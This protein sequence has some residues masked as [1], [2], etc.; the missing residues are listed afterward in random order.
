VVWK[1]DVKSVLPKPVDEYLLDEFADSFSSKPACCTIIDHKIQVTSD[2]QPK[3]MRPYR[4][5]EIMKA[6]VECQIK[7][8]LDSG[9]IIRSNSPMAS[10]LV[11]VAKKQGGVR[12]A[13]D[14]R[15]V[16]SFTAPDPFPLVTVD[17]VIHKVGHGRLISTFDAKSGYWQLLVSPGCRWLIAFVTHEGV[18]EWVR[19]PFGLRN[20]GAIFVRAVTSVLQPLQHLQVH[21]MTIWL[22][23]LQ[24]GLHI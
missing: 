23:D 15:Y 5:P 6:D 22:L 8:L 12:L 7:E 3:R 14:F 13:C 16:N 10:P 21:M 20:A 19:M 9:M 4:V 1:R 18:Y 2:F 11:C 24:V 17:E